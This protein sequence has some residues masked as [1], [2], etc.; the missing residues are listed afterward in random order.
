MNLAKFLRTP[1]L[2]NTSGQ[3]LLKYLWWSFF[4]E[5]SY[6]LKVVNYHKCLTGLYIHFLSWSRSSHQRCSIIK[7]VLR[8]FAKFTGKH[9]CQSLFSSKVAGLQENHR[10]SFC[11]GLLGNESEFE[12]FTLSVKATLSSNSP[13]P[14]RQN[15]DWVLYDLGNTVESDKHIHKSST[16]PPPPI[17]HTHT[18]P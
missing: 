2:L 14:K 1:F 13:P 12:N 8:N 15:R 11:E 5:N 16:L 10:K 6:C 7:G 9:L 4:R 18:H 17:L 3:L